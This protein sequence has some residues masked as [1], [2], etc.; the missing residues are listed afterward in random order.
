MIIVLIIMICDST[1]FFYFL[2]PFIHLLEETFFECPQAP[3][4]LQRFKTATKNVAFS[5]EKGRGKKGEEKRGRRG[6]KEIQL[7]EITE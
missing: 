2:I 3:G 4:T 5:Y 1:I 7:L 6:K